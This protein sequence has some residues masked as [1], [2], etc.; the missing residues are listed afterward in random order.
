[1][2]IL[3]ALVAARTCG[4][5]E[6]CARSATKRAEPAVNT[7]A[8]RSKGLS[9]DANEGAASV[10][11]I[12]TYTPLH[13]PPSL[14]RNGD[15]ALARYTGRALTSTVSTAERPNGC[16]GPTGGTNAAMT[17][18]VMARLHAITMARCN[19]RRRVEDLPFQSPS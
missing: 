14:V 7:R 9:H 5:T 12:G 18:G 11:Q 17:G 15:L 16:I 2:S 8:V 3:L 1:M 19:Q 4:M 6:L 13:G 10:E